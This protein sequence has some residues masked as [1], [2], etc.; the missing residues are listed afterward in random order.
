[1]FASSPRSVNLG[2]PPVC[3]DCGSLDT[4]FFVDHNSRA[5]LVLIC[6]ACIEAGDDDFDHD[7]DTVCEP[8]P[9]EPREGARHG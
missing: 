2:N 4:Y 8:T 6:E 3:P 5:P 9:L 7:A 1:M